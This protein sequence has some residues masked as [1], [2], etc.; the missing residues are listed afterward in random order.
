MSEKFLSVPDSG[1]TRALGETV[2]GF[3]TKGGPR[4]SL[5]QLGLRTLSPRCPRPSKGTMHTHVQVARACA[6]THTHLNT[7]IEVK[8]PVPLLLGAWTVITTAT[9][10]P[11]M[12][13]HLGGECHCLLS[14]P[15]AL[16]H[17]DMLASFLLQADACPRAFALMLSLPGPL[18]SVSGRSCPPPGALGARPASHL[19]SPEV[20]SEGSCTWAP[21]SLMAL[22]LPALF[23]APLP[24][25]CSKLG[26]RAHTNPPSPALQR[27]EFKQ[28][29]QFINHFLRSD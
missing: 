4:Q 17:S 24:L 6:H 29:D 11:S 8:Q 25:P 16:A 5:Q 2:G 20:P 7:T 21:P 28:R 26:Q 22:F 9:C 1:G 19:D 27:R 14:W 3:V 12:G 15:T 13:G 23:A 10:W 18:S